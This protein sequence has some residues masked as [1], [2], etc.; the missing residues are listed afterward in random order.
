MYFHDL[1]NFREDREVRL[2]RKEERKSEKFVD[3]S[4]KDDK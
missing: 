3:I 4:E 1:L 2:G